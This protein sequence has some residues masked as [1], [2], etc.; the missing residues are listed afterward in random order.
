M[1]VTL[2]LLALFL[3]SLLAPAYLLAASVLAVFATLGLTMLIARSVL[4]SGSL[5]YL[6]SAA[7]SLALAMAR[8]D[9][10]TPVA[11]APW[12]AA[13]RVC[14]PVP[15]PESSTRP[16]SR[17]CSASRTKAGCGRPMS[18]AAG[19]LP[20]YASSQLG[21]VTVSHRTGCRPSSR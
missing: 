1:A 10:S 20:V 17:P 18:H 9:M 2:V 15:Q 5:V 4:G 16:A 14:S 7:F 13:S 12:A 8:P 11:S 3:R 6:R 21:V 19:V